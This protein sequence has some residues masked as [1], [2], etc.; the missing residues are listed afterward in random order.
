MT[1]PKKPQQ[2]DRAKEKARAKEAAEA[3]KKARAEEKAKARRSARAEKIARAEEMARAKAQAKE[4]AEAEKRARAEAEAE[5]KAQAKKAAQAEKRA[6]AEEEVKA[7]EAAEAEKKARAEETARAKAQAREAARAENR[8]KAEEKVKA[9]EAAKAEKKARAGA[10]PKPKAKEAAEARAKPPKKAVAKAKARRKAKAKEAAEA[11]KKAKAEE[12]ARARQEAEAQKKAK[13]E[14]KVKAKE[15]AKAEKKARA[16]QK[17]KAKEAAEA[18]AKPPKKAVAEAKAKK[19]AK[20]APRRAKKPARGMPRFPTLQIG[21]GKGGKRIISL[22]VEGTDLRLVT[23]YR[24]SIESWD[25]VPLNPQFLQMGHVADPEGLGS[26][27]KNALEGKGVKNSHVVCA[28]PEMRAVSRVISVPNMSK[29]EM[30]SAFPRE[31]RRLMTVSEEDNYIHWQALPAGKEQTQVFVL[32]VPREGVLQFLEALRL[33]G[34]KP[35]ALDLKPLALMRAV[36]QKDAIIANGESHSVEL[37]IVVDDVP[38]LIRSIFIG[39]GEVAEDYAV[40]RISDEIRRTIVTYDETNKENP[41]DPDIPIYLS[42]AAASSVPF[43]LNVAAFIGR[44]V[45]PL[46]P[47]IHCPEDFPLADFMVNV[48]LILKIL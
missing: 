20:A 36:N 29:K 2:E 47:P 48:G 26:A 35:H 37:I 3:E 39:E 34:V 21:G 42:G 28:L 38:V 24:D 11:E 12:K 46:E 6:R 31:I 8:A 32:V 41:L 15:A 19:K 7:K 4:A 17:S 10:E 9:R 33:G 18:R 23:F 40:G 16:E 5:T 13:A 1:P 45:Q 30:E 44:T 43:A 14:E 27:I 25:R 22:S